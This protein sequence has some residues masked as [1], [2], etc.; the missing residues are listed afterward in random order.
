MEPTQ[1]PD[2]KAAL[3]AMIDLAL[4]QL[5]PVNPVFHSRS[6]EYCASPG[7]EDAPF[8]SE[9]YLYPLLG[10]DE[11]R[12]VL[13]MHQRVVRALGVDEMTWREALAEAYNARARISMTVETDVPAKESRG[14]VCAVLDTDLQEG[15]VMS[16]RF[17]RDKPGLILRDL[18]PVRYERIAKQLEDAGFTV[19]AGG[20]RILS[21]E[22][23]APEQG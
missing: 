14:Q 13:A 4:V 20:T 6:P 17:P 15:V 19:H 2:P 22:E 1:T 21:R 5:G 16:P 9:G 23:V 10:K 18:D 11:A 3:A 8:L 7:D 12:T